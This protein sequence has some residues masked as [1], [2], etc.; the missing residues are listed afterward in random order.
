MTSSRGW[1]GR[2]QGKKLEMQAKN[3][4]TLQSTAQVLTQTCGELTW[5]ARQ[6]T[7]HHE[8]STCVQTQQHAI[9]C[10]R[11]KSMIQQDWSDAATLKRACKRVPVGNLLLECTKRGSGLKGGLFTAC[12][13]TMKQSHACKHSNTRNAAH[14]P[15][16]GFSWMEKAATHKRDL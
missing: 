16:K 12:H 11:T 15:Y 10:T 14:M 3:H 1:T 5:V 2:M 8:A 6:Q 9:H 4:S 13:H 7:A